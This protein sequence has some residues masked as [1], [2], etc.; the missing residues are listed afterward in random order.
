MGSRSSS[1][2]PLLL[3]VGLQ[4][5]YLM[6]RLLSF[7]FAL[8]PTCLLWENKVTPL[9]TLGKFLFLG[10][11]GCYAIVKGNNVHVHQIFS[12]LM[13]P[14][15]KIHFLLHLY[16]SSCTNCPLHQSKDNKKLTMLWCDGQLI[17][18]LS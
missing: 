9:K 8:T 18:E 11:R 14:G 7:L 5:S 15:K 17:P 1:G 6:S 13:C 10:G 12:Q 4:V 16:G 2:P 3:T